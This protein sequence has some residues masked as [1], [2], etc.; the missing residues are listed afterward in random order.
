MIT[1]LL[2]GI[3]TPAMRAIH[4]SPFWRHLDKVGSR[5]NCLD[6]RWRPALVENPERTQKVP[7]ARRWRRDPETASGSRACRAL[8]RLVKEKVESGW[9][10]RAAMSSHWQ[11]WRPGLTNLEVARLP[12]TTLFLDRL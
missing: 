4:P 3:L 1:R 7:C 6:V 11:A 10:R 2:V 8:L 9:G 12:I 5:G